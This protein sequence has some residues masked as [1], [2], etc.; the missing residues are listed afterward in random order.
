M[1]IDLETL[2]HFIDLQVA[3]QT[4]FIYYHLALDFG[5][6]F[7]HFHRKNLPIT[8]AMDF[9]NGTLP[10]LANLRLILILLVKVH[11]ILISDFY[12]LA[13]NVCYFLERAQTELF[14]PLCIQYCV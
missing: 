4:R 14:D 11:R 7:C 9:E 13:Y 2:D 6:I 1:L 3:D 10:S 12:G 5:A 8:F